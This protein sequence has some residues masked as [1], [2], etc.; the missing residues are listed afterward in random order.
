MPKQ[1]KSPKSPY[2]LAWKPRKCRHCKLTFVPTC[3]DAANAKRQEF[4][5]AKCRIDY[6]R[7]GGMNM[8]QLTERA[9]NA[10][11]KNLLADENFL[12]RLADKVRVGL[13]IPASEMVT[14]AD[15]ERI[16]TAFRDQSVSAVSGSP[17][18]GAQTRPALVDREA[19]NS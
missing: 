2:E 7:N 11:L 1:H 8:T 10:V 16:L 13:R 9:T 3:R 19:R 12:E 5:T 14:L 4:C 17:V 15:K 6:H 18:L